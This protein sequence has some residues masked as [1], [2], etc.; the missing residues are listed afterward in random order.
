MALFA[1]AALLIA[2]A[3]VFGIVNYTVNRRTH[4]IGI[5]IAL[6]ATRKQVLA[7][8]V[9]GG[10]RLV[11][12]GAAFGIVGVIV[13]SQLLRS[14]LFEIKSLDLPTYIIT[15]AVLLAVVA[16]AT[17]LP[18]RRAASIDPICALRTE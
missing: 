16:A 8:V 10:A 18:A 11:I 3:G 1:L 2:A 14:M 5:R 7:M 9:G 4:E 17:L 13:A 6:G 15:G 12:T